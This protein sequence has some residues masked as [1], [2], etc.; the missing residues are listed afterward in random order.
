MEQTLERTVN[1]S[2]VESFTTQEECQRSQP[3]AIATLGPEGTD[4]EAVAKYLKERGI[5]AEIV[6]CKT[7][8]DAL[9]YARENGSYL[10]VPTA[11]V[12]KDENGVLK[13]SWGKMHFE[14][15]GEFTLEEVFERQ[16]QK[17]CV[18]QRSDVQ[19]P[20]NIALHPATDQF[21]YKYLGDKLRRSYLKAKPEAVRRCSEGE[22]DMC[23]GSVPVVEQFD[24]LEIIERF[25]PTMVWTLYKPS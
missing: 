7:F 6:L 5:A 3:I 22:F 17:M 21:A 4:S 19:T 8:R 15:L 13:D 23:I 1:D 11:Y 12:D 25:S 24:N 10:L 16:L 9:H 2:H 14:L 18:A 20:S